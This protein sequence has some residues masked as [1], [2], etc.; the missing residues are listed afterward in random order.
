M[1]CLYR[2]D[3]GQLSRWHAGLHEDCL[4]SGSLARDDVGLDLVVPHE[5]PVGVA[6]Q[7]LKRH[8]DQIGLR[9][10]DD[11]GCHA[12]GGRWPPRSTPRRA[13]NRRHEA[14]CGRDWHRR[15]GRRQEGQ[16]VPLQLVKG[17]GAL[18]R[19]RGR[20][21]LAASARKLCTFCRSLTAVSINRADGRNR[22][23]SDLFPIFHN[24]R[25]S[26]LIVPMRR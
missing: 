25:W 1:E 15:S 10:A 23:P 16:F 13:R 3:A 4:Q 24:T 26:L 11:Q 18:G 5:G 20:S 12:R 8:A 17:K 9:V 7:N 6:V 22:L 14:A 2:G 21:C 19:K